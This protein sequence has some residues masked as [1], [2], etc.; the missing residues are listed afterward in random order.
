MTYGEDLYSVLEEEVQMYNHFSTNRNNR[1][2]FQNCLASV[3]IATVVIATVVI[4]TN[5]YVLLK[6]L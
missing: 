5:E 6:G 3:V 1:K 2:Y 4:A